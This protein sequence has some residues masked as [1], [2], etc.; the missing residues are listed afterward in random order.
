MI[1]KRFV[2]S[3]KSMRVTL[4]DSAG[5]LRRGRGGAEPLLQRPQARYE[6][7]VAD[8]GDRLVLVGLVAVEPGRP[9]D[10][11]VIGQGDR[12]GG[13]R[14]RVGA[15]GQSGRVIGEGEG[16]PPL[17][18]I[19]RDQGFPVT[20]GLREDP[21]AADAVGGAVLDLGRRERRVPVPD[22]G[23]VPQQGP[24]LAGRGADHR[25]LRYLWHVSLLV[26]WLSER[27][28]RRQRHL[29]PSCGQ[30][31]DGRGLVHI[32]WGSATDT[33]TS[34]SATGPGSS[35]RSSPSASSGKKSTDSRP[36]QTSAA[37][38]TELSLPSA[39]PIWVAVTMNGSDVACSSPTA[40]VGLV[41]FARRP[42]SAGRPRTARSAS[43]NSGTRAS[44]DGL[45]SSPVR[46]SR[47]PLL[48]KNTGIR[49]P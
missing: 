41:P 21:H 43:R 45:C 46:S 10:V 34:A 28:P 1:E 6:H 18:V 39:T 24:D 12:P 5:W 11:G 32:R 36:A 2:A 20:A 47:I 22:G 38:V 49:K 31:G 42:S 9:L 23:E 44:A 27:Q 26:G 15:D 7:A 14:G 40:I 16:N 37:A 3:R 8:G 30:H 13:D 4:I 35:R 19:E 25:A 17:L 48:T 29:P 33:V